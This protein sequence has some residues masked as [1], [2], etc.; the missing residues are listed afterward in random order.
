MR[1]LSAMLI[2]DS[3]SIYVFYFYTTRS[4]NNLVVIDKDSYMR[5]FSFAV[6]EKSQIAGTGIL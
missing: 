1:V 2:N 6:F 3:L 5:D 4:V